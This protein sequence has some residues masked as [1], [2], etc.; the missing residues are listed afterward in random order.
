MLVYYLI[1]WILDHASDGNG[2]GF[3]LDRR[4]LNFYERLQAAQVLLNEVNNYYPTTECPPFFQIPPSSRHNCSDLAE[5]KIGR[6]YSFD[7]ASNF[8]KAYANL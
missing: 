3:P 7:K 1:L 5:T 4:Y 8:L 2:Y 6:L